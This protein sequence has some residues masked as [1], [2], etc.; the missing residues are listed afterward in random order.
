MGDSGPIKSSG[1][2]LGVEATSDT[3]LSSGL[4]GDKTWLRARLC[5]LGGQAG[6]DCSGKVDVRLFP[7]RHPD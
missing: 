6:N 7:T 5:V 3:Y 4:N 1:A 2:L